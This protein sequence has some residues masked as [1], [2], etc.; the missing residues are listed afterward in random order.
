MRAYN[1]AEQLLND[2][3]NKLVCS[4]DAQAFRKG[5]DKNIKPSLRYLN[6]LYN[7]MQSVLA[8]EGTRH[9]YRKSTVQAYC[10]IY[11]YFH[12][13]PPVNLPRGA[14]DLLEGRNRRTRGVKRAASHKSDSN[15]ADDGSPFTMS[16][17]SDRVDVDS[18]VLLR[19]D[20]ES[21][22]DTGE[23]T[24]SLV[25]GGRNTGDLLGQIEEAFAKRV[26][27]SNQSSSTSGSDLD[28]CDSETTE[29]PASPKMNG[30]LPAALAET[31]SCVRG[32][33]DLGAENNGN[34]DSFV[35]ASPQSQ[36]PR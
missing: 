5:G 22:H 29:A 24:Y 2:R 18:L 10:E 34:L 27:G 36:N 33:C 14:M 28:T 1:Q 19:A 6:S 30:S 25:L 13:R 20:D 4:D 15:L 35:V 17:L 26:C 31:L 23:S 21:A 8:N 3:W 16:W 11:E 12:H 32:Y 9:L 7:F